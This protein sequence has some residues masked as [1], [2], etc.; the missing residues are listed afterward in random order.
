MQEAEVLK[1]NYNA[2]VSFTIIILKTVTS[3][4]EKLSICKLESQF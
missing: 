2:E 1:E 3:M 4:D